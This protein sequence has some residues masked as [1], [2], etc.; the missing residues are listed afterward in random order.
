[1]E[2]DAPA[3]DGPHKAAS[4]AK[5]HPV[6]VEPDAGLHMVMNGS[7]NH[8]KRHDFSWQPRRGHDICAYAACVCVRVCVCACVHMRRVCACVRAPRTCTVTLVSATSAS[9]PH[10]NAPSP[11]V[12]SPTSDEWHTT[13]F[14][15]AVT[16][17]PGKGTQV[18]TS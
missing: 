6:L 5:R 10:T 1:M 14:F 4:G 18:P 11:M 12:H 3:E 17:G 13:A 8:P 15:A 16:R 7:Q 9:T 2:Y